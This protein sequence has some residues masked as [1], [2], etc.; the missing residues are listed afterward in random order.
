[1]ADLLPR[2]CP[3]ARIRLLRSAIHLRAQSNLR[4]LLE[5]GRGIGWS[6]AV[7]QNLT[8]LFRS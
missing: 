4:R 7:I 6:V 1:M 2:C 8:L 5:T 3:A